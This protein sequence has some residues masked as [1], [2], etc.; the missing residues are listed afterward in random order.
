MFFKDRRKGGPQ[1]HFIFIQFSSSLC[2]TWSFIWNDHI[3]SDKLR[4]VAF[5]LASIN[6]THSMW[7]RCQPSKPFSAIYFIYSFLIQHILSATSPPPLLPYL[8]HL[9]SLLDPLLLFLFIREQA[10]QWYNPLCHS[11]FYPFPGLFLM[12]QHFLGD[13]AC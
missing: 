4:H 2:Q 3:F 5:V 8:F 9:P 11:N 10:S 7:Q 13:L 12:P 6:L 1:R